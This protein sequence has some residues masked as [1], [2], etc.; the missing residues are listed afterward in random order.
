L[1]RPGSVSGW[2][3]LALL[4]ALPAAARQEVDPPAASG[5]SAPRLA[6]TA[7]GDAVA[8]WIEPAVGGARVRFARYS[9]AGWS[10]PVTIVEGDKLFANWADLPGVEQAGDGALVA[11]WLEK[12]AAETYAYG[13]RVARSSDDGASW[14]PL[15]WLN[16]DSTESEHGFVSMVAEGARLRAFWLDGRATVVGGATSL[17]TT[18]VGDTVAPSRAVDEHVC[19]CCKTAAARLA[20]GARVAYRDRSPDEVRDIAVATLSGAGAPSRVTVAAD[21]WKINGCPVNGPAIVAEGSRLAVAWYSAADDHGR[22]ALAM[23]RD[24]GA[25]FGAP[26]V[27]DDA[28]PLGRVALARG[29]GDEVIVGWIGRAGD[30]AEVRLARA[31]A[32]SVARP[33]AVAMTSAGRN[34]GF[35]QLARLANGSLLVVWTEA[36][37]GA[38]TRLRGAVFTLSELPAP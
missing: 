29:A 34:S 2:L 7:A 33:V 17:R 26:R 8:A 30:R 3:V 4:V 6:V 35:P 21:G 25:S 31:D 24:G 12:V 13:I 20:D 23:S 18:T 16:D 38:A 9:G 1:T 19:D 14:K 15:G 36:A 22:V 27:V 32:P 10:A 5:A 37:A 28:A 11:W